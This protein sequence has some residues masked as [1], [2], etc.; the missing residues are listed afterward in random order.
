[1]SIPQVPS[2]G[3]LS[4]VRVLDLT[5]ALAGP[6]CTMLLADLG[7][8]VVKVEPPNGDMTRFGG[9]FTEE[10]TQRA[11]GGYFGSIN[12]SKRS[13]VLDLKT[14]DDRDVLLQLVDGADMLIENA[15]V[16]V[17]ERLGLGYES[18]AAH[19]PKLVYGCVR[20]F[21]DPRTGESPYATWPAFDVV[22]QAMGGLVAS[23]GTRP[24]DDNPEQVLKT[25]PSIGDIYPATLLAVGVLAALHHAQRT[26][27]GQFV[28]VAMYDSILALC[29]Q[30]AERYSYTGIDATP[31]GNGHAVLAPFDIYPTSDGWCAIAAPINTMWPTLC[32]EMGR[33]DLIDDP[34]FATNGARVKNN[35]TLAGVI[36]EWTTQRSTADVVHSL[37]GKVPVGPVNNMSNI[38]D[39]PHIAAR[40]MLPFVEQPDGSRAVQIAGCPIK[41]TVTP[42][43]IRGRAPRLGEHTAEILA[44]CGIHRHLPDPT[45]PKDQS[46]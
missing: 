26:G 43:G 6:F 16:G 22:A 9:P 17:M 31:A 20:G 42:S 23:T 33:P 11:Y 4:G 35:S 30:A 45:E 38:F 3:P 12:R 5:Q 2:A 28:D 15:R 29:E 14:D 8:D 19:N 32:E 10:D 25:G 34:L 24:T 46:P 37:G 44:E 1:M 41:L 39:D 7:A 27:E 21:G 40:N 18:L 13:I 36:E